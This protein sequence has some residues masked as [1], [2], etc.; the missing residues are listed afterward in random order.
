MRVNF[1]LHGVLI[2]LAGCETVG[3]DCPDHATV[4]SALQS[5]ADDK[6]ALKQELQ[7]TACAI[8]EALISRDTVLANDTEIALIPPVSGG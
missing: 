2:R 5:L 7:R 8:G 1:Q 3:V 6:P 4:E